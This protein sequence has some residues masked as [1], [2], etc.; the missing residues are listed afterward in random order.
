M[1]EGLQMPFKCGMSSKFFDFVLQAIH[2]IHV[3]LM[4]FL[5]NTSDQ[6]QTLLFL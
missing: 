6:I 2:Y 5:E 1:P 4:F 3:N